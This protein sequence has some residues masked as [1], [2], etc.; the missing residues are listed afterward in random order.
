MEPK[1]KYDVSD[2]QLVFMLC[3][4]N[5]EA[6]NKLYERYNN[7]I[8]KELNN[9]KR[10]AYALKIEWQDLEQEAMVGFANAISSFNEDSE[11]K[12]STYA[13]ICIRRR[14]YNYIKKFA[15]NKNYIFKSTISFDEKGENIATN[16]TDASGKEPLNK[17]MLNES[18]KEVKSN[19][20]SKLTEEEQK[21]IDYATNGLKPDD[22]SKLTGKSVKQVY[23]ILYRA[24]NKIK[25]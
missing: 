3:D 8:Y 1:T 15:T 25:L 9:V 12:F 24:R 11:A 10:S 19:I 18:I 14:L 16:V 5:E 4:N 22:I 7:L 2:E 20:N 21:I 13:T 17:L 23:N 6:K